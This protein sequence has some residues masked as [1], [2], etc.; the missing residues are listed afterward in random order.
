MKDADCRL[1]LGGN[2]G[3]LMGCDYKKG[4]RKAV[5]VEKRC[6]VFCA[7]DWIERGK[8]ALSLR[9]NGMVGTERTTDHR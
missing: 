9:G 5:G 8:G 2:H 1:H 6:E 3:R 7:W 4:K